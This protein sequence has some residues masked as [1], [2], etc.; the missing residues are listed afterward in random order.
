MANR[1]KKFK[2]KINPEKS[3]KMI[4]AVGIGVVIVFSLI[5]LVMLGPQTPANKAKAMEDTLEYLQKATGIMTVKTFPE[6]NRALIV[7]DSAQTNPDYI[8]IARFAALKLSYKIGNEEI[9]VVLSK[10]RE[11]QVV[12]TTVTK[13]GKVIDEKTN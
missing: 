12:Y 10:D 8:T 2:K 1:K 9:T 7:Y 11:E 6:E 13:N 5:F 4:I 3:N